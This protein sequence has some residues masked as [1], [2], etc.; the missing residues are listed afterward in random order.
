MTSGSVSVTKNAIQDYTFVIDS[1]DD[2]GNRI[3]GTFQG[4][5]LNSYDQFNE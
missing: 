2:N 3:Y 4:T 5:L 1:T